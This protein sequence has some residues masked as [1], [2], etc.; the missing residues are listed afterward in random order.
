MP[1]RSRVPFG[2]C[3]GYLRGQTHKNN[4]KKS[5]SLMATKARCSAN[6]EAGCCWNRFLHLRRLQRRLLNQLL[7]WNCW[8]SLLATVDLPRFGLLVL[9]RPRPYHGFSGIPRLDPL[10][11]S[12]RFLFMQMQNLAELTRFPLLFSSIASTIFTQYTRCRLERRGR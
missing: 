11:V 2:G 3:C 7:G 8:G 6:S 1:W 10:L 12:E 5:L 4:Q 9:G